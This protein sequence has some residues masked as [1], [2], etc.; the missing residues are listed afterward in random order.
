MDDR[1]LSRA[2]RARHRRW[3]LAEVCRSPNPDYTSIY[4]L[5]MNARGRHG[6]PA[7]V[8]ASRTVSELIAAGLLESDR[9]S[10]FVRMADGA[11]SEVQ[12]Q[13]VIADDDREIDDLG[14]QL[15]ARLTDEQSQLVESL[16][17]LEAAVSLASDRRDTDSLDQAVRILDQMLAS[18]GEMREV[19]VAARMQAASPILRYPG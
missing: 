6:R 12:R 1:E 18:G 9:L 10:N 4:G 13:R 2:L 16:S 19:L 7:G 11:L 3:F 15:I 14:A 5:A 17:R 8:G